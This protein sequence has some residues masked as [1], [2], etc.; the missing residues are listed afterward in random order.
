MYNIYYGGNEIK[1]NIKRKNVKNI[2]LIVR[3]DLEVTVSANNRVPVEY[4]KKFVYSKAKWIVK[5]LTYYKNIQPVNYDM[6]EYVNGED[7]RYLGRKYKLKVFKSNDEY[8]K[9]F[10]GY[11]HLYVGDIDDFERKERLLVNWYKYRSQIVFNDSL[12]RVYNLVSIYD[13]PFPELKIRKMKSRWG[14]CYPR[15][16]KII[17]NSVLIKAPKDCIDYVIL[18]ELIHFKYR[19]HGKDFYRLLSII[20]PDWK[21]KKRVLDEDIVGEL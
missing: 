20:M 1:F 17:I 13:I 18:H 16:N 19:D 21:D 15:G 10:R 14:T 9:Y 6:K 5:H 8:V 11:I 7:L 4:I 3:P 12:N 2:N